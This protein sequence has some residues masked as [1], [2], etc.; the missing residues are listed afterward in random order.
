MDEGLRAKNT[1]PAKKRY[2]GCGETQL[3]VKT[4]KNACR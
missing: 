1:T 2:V 3:F 4:M